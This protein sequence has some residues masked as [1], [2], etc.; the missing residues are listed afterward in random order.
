MPRL[1]RFGPA[2]VPVSVRSRTLKGRMIRLLH[3]DRDKGYRTNWGRR[4]G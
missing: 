1:R 3:S 2:F 4:R